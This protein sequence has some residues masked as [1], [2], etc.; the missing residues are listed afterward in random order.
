MASASPAQVSS[1]QAVTIEPSGVLSS[2]ASISEFS[3]GGNIISNSHHGSSDHVY[4]MEDSSGS[5]GATPN[6]MRSPEEV[7]ADAERL[8]EQLK[9]SLSRGREPRTDIRDIPYDPSHEQK[10]PPRQFFVLTHAGKPVFTNR[11]I[12][13]TEGDDITNL[14]GVMHALISVFE[15]DQDKIR[16]IIA[17]PVRITFTI[18]P[19]LYYVCVTPFAEP[20]SVARIYLEH[21]HLLILSVL[22]G[23]QLERILTR[24]ANYDLRRLLSGTTTMLESYLDHLPR[25]FAILASS[26]STLR[27]DSGLRLRVADALVP[28]PNMKTRLKD[29]LYAIVFVDDK[30]VTIARPKKHTVHPADM[31][32][33]LAT[34]GSPA[35]KGSAASW[36]P[37]CLPRFNSNG[38]LHAYAS[39]LQLPSN[40]AA[41]ASQPAEAGEA[42]RENE[43]DA[44]LT[45][46]THAP[47]VCLVIVS[48]SGDFEVVRQWADVATNR[49]R[50]G[51]TLRQLLKAAQRSTYSVDELG[52]PGLRHFFFK[53]RPNVQVTSPIFN[54]I[55]AHAH[56][57]RDQVELEDE[58]ER[59][60]NLYRVVW[61]AIHAKSGQECTLKLQYVRTEAVSVMG[62][63]TKS[64]EIYIALSPRLPKS[65]AIGAANAVVSWVKREEAKL[66][67]RDAPVF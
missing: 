54:G 26:L 7:A 16:S 32:I 19:P 21:L 9:K 62:W 65:A 22:T 57:E 24:H 23:S 27:L 60:F 30:V 64:F 47:A 49:L 11:K 4:L 13:E 42:P 39:Y 5:D 66:F 36:L 28:P 29:I 51:E 25:S 14:I 31:H 46:G 3:H 48:A 43:E 41:S 52:I 56:D 61:D 33:L 15:D 18:R 63:I 53:S 10:F 37:I 40:S 50:D 35:V 17:P 34:I 20:E 45:G 67:L 38:L 55:E 6:L 8:R 12:D 2:S 58:W 44:A 59:L 1:D